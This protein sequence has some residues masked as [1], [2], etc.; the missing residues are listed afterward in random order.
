VVGASNYNGG[1]GG[2]YIFPGISSG[3]PSATA[4]NPTIQGASGSLENLGSSLALGDIDG[5]GYPDLLIGAPSYNNGLLGDGAVFGFPGN[6]TMPAVVTTPSIKGPPV[7]S[8]GM[9][10]YVAIGDLNGDGYG[11]LVVGVPNFNGNDGGVYVFP[12][13]KSGIAS[14]IAGAPTIKG[15]QRTRT[16]EALGGPISQ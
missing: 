5:D 8:I 6:K 3:I 10:A 7:S 12:G 16:Q 13:S 9:G 4:G 2:I 15:M 1:D 14:T 11:E